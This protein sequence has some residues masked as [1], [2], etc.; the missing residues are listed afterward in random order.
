MRPVIPSFA[1]AVHLAGIELA[2]QTEAQI[3]SRE[4]TMW[5]VG[6]AVASSHCLPIQLGHSSTRTLRVDSGLS[7]NR[8][9]RQ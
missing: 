5:P 2:R 1:C 4:I 9:Y 8:S 3:G 6:S 7:V